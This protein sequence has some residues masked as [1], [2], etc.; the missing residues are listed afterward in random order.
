MP[1]TT[2][3][4]ETGHLLKGSGSQIYWLATDGRRYVFPD[5][6]TLQSWLVQEETTGEVL[7]DE[8]LADH[9]IAGNITMRPGN[10]LV[11]FTSNPTMYV[12]ARGGELRPV[13][14]ALAQ[15][16]YGMMWQTKLQTL[17]VTQFQNYR[18][19]KA[20][21]YTSE[22][23]PVAEMSFVMTP[24]TE[25]K[26]QQAAGLLPQSKLPFMADV[27]FTAD[28]EK[29]YPPSKPSVVTYKVT[30][31]KT[32]TSLGNLRINIYNNENGLEK[33]CLASDICNFVIDYINVNVPITDRYYAI[34]TNEK[35][36]SVN[37]VYSPFLT[38][39]PSKGLTE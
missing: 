18:V 10:S 30:V 31:K 2:H 14:D 34:V 25:I 29:I 8:E 4:A 12:V 23:E 7:S 22:F 15:A 35:S 3:A 32:N 17:D 21:Q 5:H 26:L 16:F 1:L 9:P 24:D 6:P 39:T 19:G 36:E 20:I 11:R 28:Q 27:S 38:V 37:R 33:T 13:S